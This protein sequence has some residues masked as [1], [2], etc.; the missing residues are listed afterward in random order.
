MTMDYA[1][2][3]I[4]ADMAEMVMYS[5]GGIPVTDQTLAVDVI[6]EIGPF[7]DFLSHR[8]TFDFRKSQSKPRL[9]NRLV[10]DAWLKK[11]GRDL[12]TVARET[13]REILETHQPLQLDDETKAAL[14]R[15]VNEGEKAF[16]LPLS[17]H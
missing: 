7:K 15:L 5:L 6:N 11:G 1:Q 10:R 2:L 14:R 4:D 12:T 16:G 17:D 13:A 9:F 8:S 3:L